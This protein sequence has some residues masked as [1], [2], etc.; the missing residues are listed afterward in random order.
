MGPRAKSKTGFKKAIP[1]A[2]ALLA[3]AGVGWI[4]FQ[5]GRGG[6]GGE[7]VTFDSPSVGSLQ[8]GLTQAQTLA[9]EGDR[10]FEAGHYAQAIP[11]Y[12][13]A[14]QADGSD[15][16]SHND[17]GLAL[18]Y[19]GRSEEAVKE[20]VMATELAPSFPNAWL[21]LGFVLSSLGRHEEARPALEHVVKIARG[22]AQAAEAERMLGS[23]R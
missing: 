16:D 20:L 6:G 2:L 1:W 19:V 17:L 9:A 8:P 7:V 23:L 14:L 5:A 12:Q 21:S 18:H 10:Q 15:A 4:G 11:L 22:S 13:R 3:L